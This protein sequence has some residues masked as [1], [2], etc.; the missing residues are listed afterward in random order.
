MLNEVCNTFSLPLPTVGFIRT[1]LAWPTNSFVL[2]FCLART[3]L[4]ISHPPNFGKHNG[5]FV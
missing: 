1:P 4:L 5:I 2:A 3:Y